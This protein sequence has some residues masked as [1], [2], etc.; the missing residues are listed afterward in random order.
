MPSRHTLLAGS[1]FSLFLSSAAFAQA[2][3][4]IVASFSILG[5]LVEQV[6]GD[7]VA[8]TT[9]VG[10]D[11]DAHVYQPTPADA[12][13]VASADVVFVNGLGFEGWLDR[14]VDASET[15]AQ[16][17]VATEGITPHAFEEGE[18]HEEEHAEGEHEEEHAGHDHG[19]FDPHAWQSVPNAK[20]YVANIA[21]A[22]STADPAGADA[23]AANAAAYT[24]KLDA[25]DAEIRTTIAAVPENRRT[26]VTTHD[27]FGYF[28]STYGLAF[29]APQG[30]STESEASAQDVAALIEQIRD[31][32]IAAVFVEN[33]ADPRLLEQIA[34]ETDATIGGTLYSDALSG[35]DGPAP[36]YLEMMR[37]N[38]TTLAQALG[39]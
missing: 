3:I 34:S 30:I 8:V 17:V 32:G 12:Q 37:Y 19:A 21:A 39:V 16:V 5:D 6:G 22:L 7:R 1:I 20:I 13:A 25:L 23:Y 15:Q 28:A 29:E 24:E 9:L 33:I 18:E 2:P 14:L 31:E 27:A 10:P 11:G 36:T 26:I 35:P 38:L 4:D